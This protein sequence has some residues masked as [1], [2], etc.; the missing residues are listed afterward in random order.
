[1]NEKRTP[2]VL[3]ISYQSGT[4]FWRAK[5]PLELLQ[6]SRICEW[7]TLSPEQ[8]PFRDRYWMMQWD[9]VVFH[10]SWNDQ[11]AILAQHFKT[12]GKRIVLSVDDLINWNKIPRFIEGAQPYS[13]VGF[14]H[15]IQL[16]MDLADRVVVTQPFLL[17]Q[18]AHFY[19][20]PKSK[21][22]VFPNLPSFG[23]LARYFNPERKA[24]EFC[25]RKGKLRIGVI[26]ALTHYSIEGKKIPDDLDVVVEA[27]SKLKELKHDGITW[28]LPI[29]KSNCEITKR[30]PDGV[31]VETRDMCMIRNYPFMLDKLNLDLV[32]VPLMDNDFN[33]SKSNIK[34]LECSAMGIR[35][36]VQNL[37]PYQGFCDEQD[38]FS[39]SDSLV[40]K[41]VEFIGWYEK[42]YLNCV[43]GNY[44]R[45]FENESDYYG[46][47]LKTYWLENNTVLVG[48]TFLGRGFATD[49]NGIVPPDIKEEEEN[50]K[51]EKG[52]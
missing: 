17:D 30:F 45:F 7:V 15:N 21:F 32:V 23:W 20:Q 22:V 37:Y 46:H 35:F 49:A 50:G 6:D 27:S 48:D 39:D 24:K 47:K 13:E 28:V 36:L 18:L 1:M 12:I 43:K 19:E 5:N 3:L 9:I 29:G 40:S 44:K 31:N 52:N 11:C 26:S 42:R 33:K 4:L 14:A 2:K 8:I 34:L 25:G 10:Q 16:M 41:I 38:M 51:M